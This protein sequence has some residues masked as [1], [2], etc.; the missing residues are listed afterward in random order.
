MESVLLLV[1]FLV[2]ILIVLPIWTLV[3]L[4]NLRRENRELARRLALLEAGAGAVPVVTET[5][6]E[7]ITPTPV[8]E[9]ARMES[10]LLKSTPADLPSE[11]AAPARPESIQSV[12][13]GPG[14][15]LPPPAQAVAPAPQLP[16]SPPPLPFPRLPPPMPTRVPV[17]VA[18]RPAPKPR[19]NWEVFMGVKLF[20]WIGGLALFLG[21]GFFVKYS[22]EHDLKSGSP[23][24]F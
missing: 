19:I 12:E 13:G 24:V 3:S 11:R 2:G 20:A 8:A 4:S 17:P 5:S 6:R 21:V 18:A 15:P 7:P 16:S 22:F 14:V 10:D 1:L 9:P 23:W